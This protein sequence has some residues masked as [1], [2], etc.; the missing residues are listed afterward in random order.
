MTLIRGLGRAS[1]N[2]FIT[3]RCLSTELRVF[4]NHATSVLDKENKVYRKN[5]ETV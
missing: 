2:H 3:R 4:Q 1:K 5:V